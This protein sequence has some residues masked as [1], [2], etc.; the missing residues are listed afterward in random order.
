VLECGIQP[1]GSPPCNISGV[2]RV[3]WIRCVKIYV[4]LFTYR[5]YFSN[6]L[7]QPRATRWYWT[8]QICCVPRRS[9]LWRTTVAVLFI[10]NWMQVAVSP[11]DQFI[12]T[13]DD[14]KKAVSL[15]CDKS[16]L[17]LLILV[18]YGSQSF[19]AS[20][21]DGVGTGDVLVWPCMP[22]IGLFAM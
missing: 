21:C 20:N 16:A 8:Q 3:V 2:T 1:K 19:M 15:W 17:Q 14:N 22:L 18:V 10:I 13:G 12:L 5:D 7:M 9:G 6:E 11:K 4:G